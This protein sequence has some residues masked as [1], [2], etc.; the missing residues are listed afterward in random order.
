M[1]TQIIKS[2]KLCNKQAKKWLDNLYCK[3]L[4]QDEAEKA[5]LNLVNYFKTLKEIAERQVA[6]D[7][8][9]QT[10]HTKNISGSEVKI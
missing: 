7:V 4:A 3:N 1:T 2:K 5:V 6:L 9:N 8:A 10:R